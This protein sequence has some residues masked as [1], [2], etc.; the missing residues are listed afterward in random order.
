MGLND[1]V[2]AGLKYH[3]EVVLVAQSNHPNRLGEY[4]ALAV[5]YTHL[6][7]Y[8]RQRGHIA[9]ITRLYFRTGINQE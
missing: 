4:R 5:S 9:R 8:K 2:I 7:V 1:E 3:P 6:D